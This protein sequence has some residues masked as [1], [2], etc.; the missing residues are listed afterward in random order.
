MTGYKQ[1]DKEII[2]FILKTYG[3]DSIVWIVTCLKAYSLDELHK[4]INSEGLIVRYSLYKTEKELK[5]E[6]KRS[7]DLIAFCRA[8]EKEKEANENIRRMVS[9]SNNYG[10]GKINENLS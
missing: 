2:D 3:E 9:L 6:I 1:V 4:K 10:I 8:W 7:N 5:E